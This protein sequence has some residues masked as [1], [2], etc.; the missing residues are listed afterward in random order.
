MTKNDSVSNI[1]K[2][3]LPERRTNGWRRVSSL[4]ITERQRWDWDIVADWR[5]WWFWDQ[6]RS[7]ASCSSSLELVAF[8]L[9]RWRGKVQVHQN[10]L[11]SKST[12][13]KIQFH[14]KPLSSKTHFHQ[15]PTFI[16]NPLSSKTHFHQ[17]PTSIKNPLSS[18]NHFHQKPFSS[19]SLSSLT[20]QNVPKWKQ[21]KK[22]KQKADVKKNR[23]G[24]NNI[25]RVFW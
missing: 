9:G 22:E 4:S 13:I 15:K 2:T 14:Q 23:G 1:R 7:G 19:K 11:S 3:K 24:T 12:F 20:F 16:K 8:E 18:K 25:V 17:K 6:S 5:G 21:K 10:P